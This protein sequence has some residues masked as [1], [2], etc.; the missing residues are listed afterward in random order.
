M[1]P[2]EPAW[3][4]QR[5]DRDP[6][7][8]WREAPLGRSEG[9]ALIPQSCAKPA[10]DCREMNLEVLAIT[11]DLI[12]IAA[13]DSSISI[14]S[15]RRTAGNGACMLRAWVNIDS[16]AARVDQHG[17]PAHSNAAAFSWLRSELSDGPLL[18]CLRRRFRL[19]K[20]LTV[21]PPPPRAFAWNRWNPGERVSWEAVF[22]EA[23]PMEP[24][25]S[26]SPW[27]GNGPASAVPRPRRAAWRPGG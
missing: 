26:P 3:A 24:V 19:A 4:R 1:L 11:D 6:I 2:A 10:C 15:S 23:T 20:H 5:S 13:S 25:S 14:L 12:G 18:E 22:P 27:R 8:P 21:D 17:M 9:L 7:L 16:D